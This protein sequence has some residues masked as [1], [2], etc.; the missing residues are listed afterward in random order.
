MADNKDVVGLILDVMHGTPQQYSLAEAKDALRAMV[1]DYTGGVTKV[2]RQVIR[3]GTFTQL[4]AILEEVLPTVVTDVLKGN[5]MEQDTAGCRALLRKYIVTGGLKIC[6][7][8]G[9]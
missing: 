5:E 2:T 7:Y 4:F 6:F 3:N 9:I 8:S 1:L